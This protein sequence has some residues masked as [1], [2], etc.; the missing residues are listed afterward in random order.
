MKDIEFIADSLIKRL[1]GLVDFQELAI[2]GEIFRLLFIKNNMKFLFSCSLHHLD[3][4]WHISCQIMKNNEIIGFLEKIVN[5][6]DNYENPTYEITPLFLSNI[7]ENIN[8]LVD[9]IKEDIKKII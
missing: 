5:N 3:I 8:L 6:D 9:N 2:N 4:P 7:N 1:K